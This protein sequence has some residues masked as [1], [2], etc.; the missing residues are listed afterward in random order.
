MDAGR[1]PRRRPSALVITLVVFMLVLAG[2][3]WYALRV[4]QRLP[5]ELAA[6]GREM[7]RAA[8]RE[9][10]ELVRAFR[11]GSVRRMF[12]T[13]TTRIE[14]TNYLQVAT[15]EQTQVFEIEDRSA[16]FWGTVELPPVIVRA[17]APVD[18]TYFVDLEGE[19]RFELRDRRVLVL[20]PL[21]RFNKPAIDISRLRWQV[22][23]GSLLRDEQQVAARLRREMMGRAAIQAK[24]NLP[25]VRETSRRQ[26]ERFVRNWLLQTFAE[27]AEGYAVEVYFAD[28]TAAWQEAV[29]PAAVRPAG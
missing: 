15:L 13:H 12:A 18:Y 16:V 10:G 3:A 27:E 22:R 6:Q 19:W 14:G 9:A 11:T 1:P 5:G 20:A 17:T 29:K 7:G 28:E 2:G 26:V 4:L 24:S 25:L 21:L 23:Q 8:V